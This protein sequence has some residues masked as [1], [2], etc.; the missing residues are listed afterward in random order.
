MSLS[1]TRGGRRG[2]TT[3]ERHGPIDRA[4][5]TGCYH[6]GRLSETARTQQHFVRVAKD[7]LTYGLL[8]AFA[9]HPRA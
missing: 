8:S 9:C 5:G 7:I 6:F 2:H 4:A 3:T 1:K